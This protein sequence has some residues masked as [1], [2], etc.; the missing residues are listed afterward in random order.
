MIV[1]FM[2]AVI[3]SI[4]LRKQ[5][6]HHAWWLVATVFIIMMSALGRGGL[7]FA[8]IGFSPDTDPMTGVY[9][10]CGTIILMA[11]AAALKCGKIRHPAT[12]VAVGINVF[13]A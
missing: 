10:A 4:R 12:W 11:L 2:C 7:Q 5:L 1:A 13:A 3:Q 8:V 9:I 6:E